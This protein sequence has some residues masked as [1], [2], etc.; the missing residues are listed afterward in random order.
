MV[1]LLLL[2]EH[3]DDDDDYYYCYCY[4]YCYY[5]YY[6]YSSARRSMDSGETVM[7]NPA[8]YTILGGLGF[9]PRFRGLGFRI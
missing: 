9:R 2:H 5:Y 7:K 8:L 4:C 1:V 6:Y 3:Y